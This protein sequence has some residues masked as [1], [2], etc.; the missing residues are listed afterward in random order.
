MSVQNLN[1]VGGSELLYQLLPLNEL[2]IRLLRLESSAGSSTEIRASL[3][4]YDLLDVKNGSPNFEALSYTWGQ[5]SVTQNIII[6]GIAFPVTANL[7]AFLQQ[8]QEAGRGVDL[9]IDAICVNQNDLLEKNHQIPM[10]N[11][12]YATARALIIWL[13][14]SSADSD[15]ALE[16]INHLGSGSPYDKMPNIPNDTWQAMQ[17]LLERPW[18]KRIW[19]VQELT[20]GAMGKKLDKASLLCGHTR[21][22]WVNLV[23]AAA[24]MKA[25]QDDKRQVFPTITEILELDSLRDSAGNYLLNQPTPKAL[26]DLICRYRHF[27]ATDRRDKIYAIWNMFT[28][29]PSKRLQTRYDK[30]VEEVYVDFVTEM[31]LDEIGLEVLRH[32]G[33]GSPDIPSWV[34]DWSV[35]PTS[36]SLPFRNIQ[37]YFDVPWWAEPEYKTP[38]AP[39]RADGTAKASEV[40]YH[41][42]HPVRNAEDEKMR[43]R[44]IKRLEMTANGSAVIKSLDDIPDHFTLHSSCPPAVKQQIKALLPRGDFVLVVADENPHMP[45]NPDALQQG[46]L[47]TER[48]TKKWLLQ[49]LRHS[50]AKPLYATAT[51]ANANFKMSKNEK[52]LQVKG[53]L[54]DELEVCHDSF[55][56]DIE[57]NF[58]N[59]THFMVA[60]GCCKHLA[61]SNSSAASKYPDVVELL[62]AFW[63]TL[64]VG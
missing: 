2:K 24:R 48:Q 18:W 57:R 11:M 28:R 22:S 31:M 40:R 30:S 64:F 36:L 16:W 32:C 37:R 26:F 44:R 7:Y 45:G 33:N 10:M 56:E 38:K 17:S 35:P 3:I 9:W 14:E 4:R 62:K 1:S 50:T 41:L 61:M 20:T 5:S 58:A 34:P 23:V 42:S 60:V 47:F 25:Y 21:V 15:L 8:E 6:N 59:A 54:W 19:I 27:L 13:G 49:E 51:L 53:I 43:K 29:E 12:I 46:E 39:V 52:S 55:V 63:S